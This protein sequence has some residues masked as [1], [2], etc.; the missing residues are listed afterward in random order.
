MFVNKVTITLGDMILL[1]MSGTSTD[2]LH[3]KYNKVVSENCEINL[4]NA[5]VSLS[6]KLVTPVL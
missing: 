1:E 3:L 6:E 4:E 5:T 2:F